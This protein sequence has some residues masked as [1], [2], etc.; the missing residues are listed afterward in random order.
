MGHPCVEK[1]SNSEAPNWSTERNQ[2]FC[3]KNLGAVTYAMSKKLPLPFSQQGINFILAMNIFNK[4]DSTNEYIVENRS[5]E[6]SGV[7][8]YP[9]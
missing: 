2:S 8:V 9:F 3:T 5:S 1:G 4:S 6:I 7:G